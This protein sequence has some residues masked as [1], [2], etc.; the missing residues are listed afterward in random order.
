MLELFRVNEH[1]IRDF[2]IS[3]VRAVG[4]N[5]H[6]FFAKLAAVYG[7]L[8]LVTK[9]ILVFN[10]DETGVGKVIAQLGR[11]HVYSITS[12]EKG[13]THTVLSWASGMIL[14]PMIIYPWKQKVPEQ[15]AIS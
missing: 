10:T 4:A 12:A 5:E 11:R 9:P 13:K 14:P 2:L 8:N 6:D 7:R 3:Y 15:K 1:V